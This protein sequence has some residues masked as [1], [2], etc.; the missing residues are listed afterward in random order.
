MAYLSYMYVYNVGISVEK[1]PAPGN[2][3]FN[4][5][6]CQ[7]NVVMIKCH[8]A[9]KKWGISTNFCVKKWYFYCTREKMMDWG[10]KSSFFPEV[11]INIISSHKS[12]WKC[13]S[14]NKGFLMQKYPFIPV[15]DFLIYFMQIPAFY[16]FCRKS[17][18]IF[19]KNLRTR[20]FIRKSLNKI[21]EQI[22]EKFRA[23]INGYFCIKKIIQF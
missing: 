15:R 20:G 2:Y 4:L 8:N 22:N 13:H 23:G 17:S 19:E 3:E 21:F 6:L 14:H 16:V 7:S 11:S 9:W 12:L 18:N 5:K 10:T 1:K